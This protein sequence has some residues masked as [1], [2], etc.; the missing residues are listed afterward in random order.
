MQ[1]D[2]PDLSW[3]APSGAGRHRVTR[4]FIWSVGKKHSKWMLWI[5]EG[6]EFD[7]SVPRWLR[8]VFPPNDPWFLKA[9]CVHDMLL[10][11]G[12]RF[13]FADSQWFEA[14]LS[15]GAPKLRTWTAY[16]LMRIHRFLRWGLSG[17]QA[18]LRSPQATS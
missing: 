14:A 11:E 8:P 4:A 1:S 15:V 18:N 17:L 3:C 16:T 2:A 9:A 12:F 13:A 7:S 5:P 10:A 6:F